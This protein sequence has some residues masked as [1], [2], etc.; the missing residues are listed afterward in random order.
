MFVLF[1]T[2]V[3]DACVALRDK[4]T[5]IK[6]LGKETD[7]GLFL[8]DED[9]KRGVW[10]ESGRTLEHYLLRE[11]VSRNYFNFSRPLDFLAAS[12]DVELRLEEKSF[13]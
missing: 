3:V 1:Q 9:P 2:T 10:L 13:H 6:G 11:N 7:Y 5:E 8:A 12:L 4:L